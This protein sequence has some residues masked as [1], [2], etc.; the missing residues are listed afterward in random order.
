MMIQIDYLYR[1]SLKCLIRNE[2]GEVLVVP[3]PLW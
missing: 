1:I 3:I 2:K